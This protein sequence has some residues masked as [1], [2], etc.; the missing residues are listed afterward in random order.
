MAEHKAMG[1]KRIIKKATGHTVYRESLMREA[2]ILRELR[3]ESVPRLCDIE[4]KDD[5][6][7]II[8]EY[9]EGKNL[10]DFIREKGVLDQ[11]GALEYAVRLAA[12]IE[13]LHFGNSF[14]VFHLDIQPKNIIISDEK[15]YL[16]DFGN[17]KTDRDFG[18][19]QR[20]MATE[21]FAPPEQYDE[22]FATEAD[23]GIR[24]DIYGFGAVLLYMLTG[25]YIAAAR[26]EKPAC[27]PK[28]LLE[29]RCGNELK[30]L[31]T[32]ALSINAQYRQADFSVLGSRLRIIK[33]GGGMTLGVNRG[34]YVISVAGIKHGVGT[35]YVAMA[36]MAQ[37]ERRGISAVYEENNDSDT[38]RSL[39]R[40][41]S[42]IKYELGWFVYMGCRLKPKY[43]KS[44]RLSAAESV[45]IRDEGVWSGTGS[46]G[47]LLLEIG[48][49]HV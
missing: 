40:A 29:G 47:Q 5:M 16:T 42:D 20:M 15:V 31:I 23:N 22:D 25:R 44:I 49:A 30:N 39:A 46:Y 45:I 48:R 26:E 35:T 3:H 24:A 11:D 8:E 18:K 37:L 33:E 4:E 17:S 6:F 43:D 2:D 34:P 19:R 38:V 7:C 32:D 27:N 14:K 36:L 12:V 21:G 28:E 9:I 1:V 41:Y 13:F 10:Y